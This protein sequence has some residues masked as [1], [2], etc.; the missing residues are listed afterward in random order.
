MGKLC[1]HFFGIAEYGVAIATTYEFKLQ[2]DGYEV[3][4][5]VSSVELPGHDALWTYVRLSFHIEL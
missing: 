4:L 3:R 1:P 5:L 2:N